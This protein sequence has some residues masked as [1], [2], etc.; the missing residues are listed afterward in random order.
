MTSFSRAF[1]LATAGGRSWSVG[2]EERDFTV[3]HLAAVALAKP[4][5]SKCSPCL[6]VCKSFCKETGN[7]LR[8]SFEVFYAYTTEFNCWEFALAILSDQEPCVDFWLR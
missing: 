2:H 6:L 3:D 4:D 7:G 1:T 5:V 8:G